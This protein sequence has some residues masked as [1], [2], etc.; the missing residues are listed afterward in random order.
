MYEIRITGIGPIVT[1]PATDTQS[2]NISIE[3]LTP[4]GQ[5][6]FGMSVAVA[7]ELAAAIVKHLRQEQSLAAEEQSS[8]TT[9]QIPREEP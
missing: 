1:E 9:D 3:V 4:D 7:V 6:A 2:R 8:P 5:N